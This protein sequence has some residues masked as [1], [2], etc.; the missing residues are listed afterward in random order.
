MVTLKDIAAACGASVSTVSRVLNGS[1]LITEERAEP[2]RRK[3]L[4]MGYTPDMSAR[5]LKTRR[6]GMIGLIYE[7]HMMH[8]YFSHVIDAIRQSAE[9]AGFDVLLLSRRHPDGRMDYTDN[10]LRRRMDG[11]VLL[12]A[13]VTAGGVERM[14]SG[15]IP[16][17]SVDECSRACSIVAADYREGTAGLIRRAAALGHRR[18]AFVHGE[19]G[20]A[21]RE[22]LAAFRE[23]MESL[24]LPLPP[25]YIRQAR[26]NDSELCALEVSALLR[27]PSPPSCVLLPDDYAA[28]GVVQILLR[29]GIRIPEDL[30]L[31][32]YD[33]TPRGQRFSPRLTTWHQN[34]AEIG[35]R[36]L[37]SLQNAMT[38]GSTR[39]FER[40][41]VH[42]ELME[43]ETLGRMP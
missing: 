3:A 43:G 8:P 29:Q 38:I 10:A 42:G 39:R 4:E 2:I 25:E 17:V 18:I 16:V 30:S 37:E 5:T 6:S 34:T 33:G 9:E 22:R 28:L 40:T 14:I 32:G 27:L 7:E 11:V 21:S 31:A 35:R 13:D 26:F 36:V 12:F 15:D 1:G 41:T 20:Y 19:M 23:T 24:S